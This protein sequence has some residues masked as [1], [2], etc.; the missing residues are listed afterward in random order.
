MLAS[1]EPALA[2]LTLLLGL[3]ALH[4]WFVGFHHTISDQHG[5][6]Q[7]QTALATQTILEGSPLILYDL[8]IFGPPWAFPQEFPLYQWLTALLAAAGMPLIEAGRTLSIS[9]FLLSLVALWKVL[10]SLHVE[11]GARLAIASLILSCPL[12][13]F[14]PRTFLIETC[15]LALSLWY[16]YFALQAVTARGRL[17]LGAGAVLGILAVMVK[18]TTFLPFWVFVASWLFAGAR[19]RSTGTTSIVIPGGILL[20]GPAIAGFAWTEL[21]SHVN[22]ENVLLAS[23]YF[24]SALTVLMFGTLAD[25][26]SPALWTAV[27][28]RILPD[29]I[30]TVLAVPFL[31]GLLPAARRYGHQ[32]SIAGALFLLPI[33]A[34]PNPH[35]VHNYY[36]TAN[37]LFLNAACG[38]IAYGLI[39]RRGAWRVAGFAILVLL[40]SG[41]IARYYG[42]YFPSANTDNQAPLEIGREV[43]R[44]T[45]TGQIIAVRGVD[46]SP[47]IP[48]YSQRRAIMD[49][50]FP[51]VLLRQQVRAV[52]PARL[53]DVLFCRDARKQSEG[54]ELSGQLDA[55]RKRYGVVM[56]SGLDDG[57]C[58]HYTRAE[59]VP[60][61]ALGPLPYASALDRPK[62]GS[63]VKELVSVEGWALSVPKVAEI[64]VEIDGLTAGIGKSGAFRPDL[65]KVFPQYPGHPF[66][67]FALRVNAVGLSS[68]RHLL[69]VEAVLEDQSK[70]LVGNATISAR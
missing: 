38:F 5:F 49:R 32:I 35:L 10:E 14:W 64:R 50:E 27:F 6:R 24:P 44:L 33:V 3:H 7:A 16:L 59:V 11:R 29:T 23:F 69:S 42:V 67:G 22:Q 60:G 37:A 56:K 39:C 9:F 26:L 36:Q 30:G 48:F 62:N 57:Q 34:F 63:V 20:V 51:E 19:R 25:R 41:G 15:A 68:G 65:V 53:G 8:P 61:V 52:S 12:Y 55:I 28:S 4:A 58:I 46:W 21:A 13:L 2:V 18:F 31:L 70:H 54:L 47:E 45:E 17:A 43:Q 1:E 40:A 66:N